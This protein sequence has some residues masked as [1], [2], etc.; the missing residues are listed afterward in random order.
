MAESN[1]MLVKAILRVESLQG[2]FTCRG[3]STTQKVALESIP[4]YCETITVACMACGVEYCYKLPL[5]A[6]NQD[7]FLREAGDGE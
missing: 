1:V 7:V 2:T 6:Q 3:C 5:F 4:G